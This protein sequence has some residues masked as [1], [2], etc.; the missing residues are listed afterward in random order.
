MAIMKPKRVNFAALACLFLLMAAM[1]VFLQHD[2]LLATVAV[3]MAVALFIVHRIRVRR[4][5]QFDQAQTF[6]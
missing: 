4:F 6:D 3:V 2:Y 5:R 1:N